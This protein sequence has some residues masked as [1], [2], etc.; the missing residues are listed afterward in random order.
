MLWP[1]NSYAIQRVCHGRIVV[2]RTKPHSM[3][4]DNMVCLYVR[5]AGPDSVVC[6]TLHNVNIP[7]ANRSP[8]IAFAQLFEVK[9]TREEGTKNMNGE[10]NR[11]GFQNKESQFNCTKWLFNCKNGMVQRIR[12]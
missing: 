2:A 6:H 4:H 9:R 7:D 5:H 8:M 11:R 1:R 12:N 3:E 10:L